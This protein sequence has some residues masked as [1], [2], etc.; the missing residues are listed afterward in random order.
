MGLKIEKSDPEWRSELPEEVYRICRE[1]GTEPPF[2]GRYWNHKGKGRYVCACCGEPL[3][4]SEK[5]FD[6]G[7]GW[8]SFTEPELREAIDEQPDASFGMNRTEILC[9]S[10][11]AHLGHLFEDGPA[12]TGLRYCVNSASLKFVPDED[13]GK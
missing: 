3:F 12:P 6:S 1:H 13:A 2:T 8:P 11:G 4:G 7:T 9:S 5:K 10:C